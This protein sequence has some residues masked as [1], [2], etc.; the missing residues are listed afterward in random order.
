MF[1]LGVIP[2]KGNSIGIPN[3]NIHYLNGKP[4]IEYTI[5]AATNSMLNDWF[6]F[7]DKYKNYRNLGIHEPLKYA[8]NAYG[9]ALKYIPYA[10]NEYEKKHRKIDAV[11]LLQ[12]TSPLRNSGDINNAISVFE[13]GQH[14]DSK[15]LYSGYKMRVK[16]KEKIDGKK[17]K[18]HFQRNGAIFITRR[19]LLK[20][21][22]LWDDKVI[23]FDMPKSRSIDIDTMDDMF[24][25]ESILKNMG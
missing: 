11:M 15:S 9:I 2:A 20:D 10:V 8:T 3:K 17:N 6:V 19:D 25:A 5:E 13:A 12:P 22:K 7:T 16:K 1:I 24:I 4:M 21:G 18:K 23:E 14:F